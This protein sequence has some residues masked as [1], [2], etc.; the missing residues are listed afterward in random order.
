[1]RRFIR[2]VKVSLL[3]KKF[4]LII[5]GGVIGLLSYFIIYMV[6]DM[7]LS[8]IEDIINAWPEGMIEFFGDVDV[9]INPYGFWSL[10][11]L[12]FM[13]LYGGVYIIYM[14]SGLLS[15]EV[16]E[17]TIDLSLSKPI[18]RDQFLGSKITFLY[19][20]IMATM[21][22]FFLITMGGMAS[23][24]KFQV[25][26]LYFDRLWL[27]YIVVV[28][29]LGAL[30]MFAKFMSTIF[31]NTRKSMALGVMFL[32]LMFFLGEF[33]IYMDEAVQDIKYISVF[34][35]FNPSDYLVHEDFGLFIRDFIVLYFINFGLV[36]ASLVVFEKKD[37]PI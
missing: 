27:T 8:A 19:I 16:E 2:A 12:S 25:E 11:L 9:F 5:L 32:F 30:A 7:D 23:S 33:Y 22:I 34:Y 18:T 10:E 36:V 31:L 21:G 4:I 14:A 28:L 1:M 15:R 17:K 20:F 3:E 24:S 13:W 29:F 6:E 37:I 35:Y 26:G